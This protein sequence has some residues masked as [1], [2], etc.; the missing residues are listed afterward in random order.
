MSR[1]AFYKFL[2]NFALLKC[3]LYPNKAFRTHHQLLTYIRGRNK[4]KVLPFKTF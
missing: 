3:V 1:I 4:G 2:G